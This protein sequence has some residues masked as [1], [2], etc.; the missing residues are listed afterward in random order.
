MLHTFQD[1]SP[2]WCHSFYLSWCFQG[3]EGV[4]SSANHCRQRCK[5]RSKQRNHDS[6]HEFSVSLCL[7]T[8]LGLHLWMPTLTS[9]LGI[10]VCR[11][12]TYFIMFTCFRR[13]SE[14]LKQTLVQTSA[15]NS[16]SLHTAWKWSWNSCIFIVWINQSLYSRFCEEQRLTYRLLLKISSIFLSQFKYIQ[17]R[18]SPDWFHRPSDRPSHSLLISRLIDWLHSWPFITANSTGLSFLMTLHDLR[19]P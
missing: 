10:K 16:D 17:S 14:A 18:K 7:L 12:C 4:C 2:G 15:E 3:P 5:S 1:S 11:T 6:R 13:Y 9:E 19:P 8:S